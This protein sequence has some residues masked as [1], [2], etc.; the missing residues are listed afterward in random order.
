MK[1]PGQRCPASSRK[2]A[3]AGSAPPLPVHEQVRRGVD[4]AGL[5]VDDHHLR[6]RRA[7]RRRQPGRGSH[8]APEVPTT[9]ITSAPLP[10]ARPRPSRASGSA[11][12]N[13]TTPGRKRAAAG[14]MRRLGR[15]EASPGSRRGGRRGHGSSQR[16]AMSPCRRMVPALPARWCR[17]STFCVTTVNTGPATRRRR[18][19][20]GGP[21]FGCARTPSRRSAYQSH[22]GAG[23][24][25][26]P[27]RWRAAPGRSATTARSAHRGRWGCRSRRHAGAAEHA[28]ARDAIDARAQLV[29]LG[30]QITHG[31]R[32]G[33]ALVQADARRPPRRSGFH[34]ALHGVRTSSSQVLAVSWRMPLPSA[35]STSATG[36]LRS[37]S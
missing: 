25:G 11:S 6:R 23:R 21:A 15:A 10:R 16:S 7:R 24:R 13:Q 37:S 27:P 29:Q 28:D 9:S 34:R 31:A 20:R 17:S 22:T 12:P 26:S 5:R 4:L 32:A 8:T 2:K 1:V 35:P 3:A 36:P 33:A 30:V 18:R 14:A 19:A